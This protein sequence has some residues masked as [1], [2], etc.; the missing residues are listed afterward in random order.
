MTPRQDIG[1]LDVNATNDEIR[2]ILMAHGHAR[3]LVCKSRLDDFEGVV[4]AYDILPDLIDGKSVNLRGRMHPPLVV[5]DQ[6][7]VV[8]LIERLKNTPTRLA[9][10]VDDQ[11]DIEG[12]VTPTDVLA[13]IAG[14]LVEEED[15]IPKSIHLPDG[16]IQFDGAVPIDEVADLLNCASIAGVG[17]YTT[18][19]SFALLKFGHVPKINESF[20]WGGWHFRV[21]A[22]EGQRIEAVIAQPGP[23]TTP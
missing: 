12:V 6:L 17:D 1:W 19:A 22:V 4:V 13:A 5:H 9:I 15:A 10:V 11:G 3:Y 8:R 18:L 7:P 2:A 16:S 20:E 23:T 21:A 14:N